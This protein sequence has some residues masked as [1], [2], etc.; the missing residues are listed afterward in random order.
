MKTSLIFV[1]TF[2]A[3]VFPMDISLSKDSLKVCNKV[4]S[5]FSDYLIIKNNSGDSIALD[6]AYLLFDDFD[7]TEM[8]NYLAPDGKLETYWMELLNESDFGWYLN[9]IQKN[10]FKLTKDYF[11]PNNAVPFRCAPNDSC[12]LHEFSIG[13]YLVSAHYP[14]YPKYLKGSLLLY[15]TNQETITIKLYSDDLRTK[16]IPEI[17]VKKRIDNNYNVEYVSLNGKK[18]MNK[19]NNA[20]CMYIFYSK[21]N[22]WVA[23]KALNLNRKPLRSVLRNCE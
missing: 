12:D 20:K 4:S 22:K 23:D 7:T 10:T 19:N 21:E 5:S 3:Y 13:I 6:S 14:I 15:F 1:I 11:Y 2:A 16:V 17:R 18:I 8:T 9:E